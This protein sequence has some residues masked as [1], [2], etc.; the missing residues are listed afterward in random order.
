MKLK[1]I[2]ALIFRIIGAWMIYNGFDNAVGF[3]MDKQSG[4]AIGA[5]I[6][7]FIFGICFIIFSK[8]LAR[9]FCRG[10]DDDAA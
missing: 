10:L 9:L 1:N 3:M 5:F 6:C 2:A 8:R 4:L 7:G